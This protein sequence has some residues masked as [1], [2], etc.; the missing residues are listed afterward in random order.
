MHGDTD[1]PIELSRRLVRIE[2][3]N[4][5]GNERRCAEFV[6][7]WFAD[8]G[9]EADLVTAPDPD[10][11]QV[12]ARVGDGDPTVVLNGHLDVVPA[13]DH[14]NWRHDPYG[15]EVE[16][17]RLYGRGSADMKSGIAVAMCATA[18]LR[19]DLVDG[20]L[21]GSVVFHGAM[22]EESGEA[23]TKT[24]L[25]RGYDGDYGVVLE[26]TGLRTATKTKGTAWYEITVEGEPS[27]AS[28]PDQGHSAV[29]DA[30]QVYDRL[31]DYD[32]RVRERA[33]DLLGTAYATVTGFEAG[34][35]ANV[36]P[37]E[38]RLV[39]DRRVLP[40]ESFEAVHAE[41]DDL[42]ASVAADH[43]LSVSWELRETL[44]PSE[45]PTDGVVAT[46]VREH[47]AAI[48]DVPTDPWGIPAG[49]D[50]RNLINDAGMEAVTWGPGDLDQAHTTDE[51]IEVAE[52]TDAREILGRAVRDLL[53]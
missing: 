37:E 29:A 19:E 45:T 10:R 11:P 35:K 44:R 32:A 17:G 13:G 31:V 38:A 27:H 16:D 33:D 3:E 28:S 1:D 12:A 15:G 5:P 51:S 20:D 2:S 26:P 21:D 42:L 53:A 36:V 25:E 41:V 40:G 9:I 14:A 30:Q 18:D 50:T 8:R 46:T 7:D 52:V 49:T 24:L 47:S 39:L 34:T 48:A 23:G 43:D 4:P 6:A 22:G